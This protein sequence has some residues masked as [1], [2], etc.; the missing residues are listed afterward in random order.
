LH[1]TDDPSPFVLYYESMRGVRRSMPAS[2]LRRLLYAIW[3]RVYR[4]RRPLERPAFNAMLRS[5]EGRRRIGARS[6]PI[7]RPVE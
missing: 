5:I 4:V 7:K 3:R 2:E 1:A 6:V